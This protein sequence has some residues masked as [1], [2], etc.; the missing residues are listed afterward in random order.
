MIIRPY[1]PQNMFDQI[2]DALEMASDFN[3]F[4]DLNE[5]AV[6]SNKWGLFE[7]DWSPKLDMYEDADSYYLK[8]DVPGI[9]AKDIEMNVTND[10]LT[11]K[12]VR[13]REAKEDESAKKGGNYARE[14]RVYGSFH[15]TIPLPVPV[16]SQKV[17][18]E[19]KDGVLYIK[20][21]KKEETKPKRISVKVS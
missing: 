11:I 15:R 21:P 8:V 12:G 14:E 6:P 2:S 1:N 17:E 18:A 9:D 7:G 3:R 4:F 13:G 19:L 20:L 16:E 5:L 10:V